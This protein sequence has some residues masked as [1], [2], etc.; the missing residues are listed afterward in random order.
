MIVALGDLMLDI[1]LRSDACPEE[2]G[3]CH[4]GAHVSAGGSAASYAVW[5]ARLGAEVALLAKAGDDLLGRALVRDLEREG[6]LSSTT[7]VRETTGLTVALV[8]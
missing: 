4:A 5:A 8:D 6:V 7:L 2:G 1:V 3:R